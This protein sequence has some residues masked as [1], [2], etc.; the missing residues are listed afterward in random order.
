MVQ[1]VKRL[2][3]QIMLFLS[4]SGFFCIIRPSVSWLPLFFHANVN[5]N[6]QFQACWIKKSVFHNKTRLF[7]LL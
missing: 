2:K 4:E 6:L 3:P 5:K 7:P 1:I